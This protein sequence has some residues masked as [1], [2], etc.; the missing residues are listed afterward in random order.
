VVT[1]INN[2]GSTSSS[3]YTL[4]TPPTEILMVQ[5]TSITSTGFTIT[6]SGGDGATSYSYNLNT[7]PA[8]PS[9]DNGVSSKSATFTGLT[10]D[11]SY[12]VVVNA[13]RINSEGGTSAFTSVTTLM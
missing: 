10:P 8:T 3:P 4:T 12:T 2:G 13:F 7:S 5:S 9:I 6:W 11:T 1:A